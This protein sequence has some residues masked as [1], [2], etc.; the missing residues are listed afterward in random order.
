VELDVKIPKRLFKTNRTIMAIDL[1]KLQEKLDKALDEET[2]GSFNEWLQKKL[3][4]ETKV[5]DALI[6]DLE[7]D[8]SVLL[9]ALEIVFNRAWYNYL[10]RRYNPEWLIEIKTR[11][12]FKKLLNALKLKTYK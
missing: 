9:E 6:K 8:N 2:A 5:K 11:N 10:I 1:N 3:F 4:E 7:D 12:E